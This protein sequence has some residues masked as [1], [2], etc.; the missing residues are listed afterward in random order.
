MTPPQLPPEM[1]GEI[2][3]YT[4]RHDLTVYC[5]ASKTFYE[6]SIAL[7]YAHI[8]V[9][10]QAQI[11][12][13]LAVLRQKP[14]L[15]ECV[16]SLKFHAFMGVSFFAVDV[17]NIFRLTELDI[18]CLGQAVLHWA[19]AHATLPCL[20]V[21]R[22]RTMGRL[23]SDTLASFLNRHPHI[24]TLTIEAGRPFSFNTVLILPAL[25]DVTG[26]P[27][28]ITS[29]SCRR[30]RRA[31]V[32][33]TQEVEDIVVILSRLASLSDMKLLALNLTV[34]APWPPDVI[35]AVAGVLPHIKSLTLQS[36]GSETLIRVD[37]INRLKIGDAV[38]KLTSLTHLEFGEYALVARFYD[39]YNPAR[40]RPGWR[41]GRSLVEHWSSKC[42]MLTCIG[43][44]GEIWEREGTWTITSTINRTVAVNSTFIPL[45]ST[46]NLELI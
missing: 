15:A 30:L 6:L 37:P 19:M 46:G 20:K 39:G 36:G 16:R 34:H 40:W 43:L 3:S 1:H 10:T 41:L 27:Q 13:L 45:T 31:A 18:S 35:L 11:D 26:P 33:W 23:N 22:A 8:V 28:L 21:F 44:Y 4:G 5:R 2:L 24:T 12:H 25:E 7:V 29:L 17:N 9:E 14:R 32:I 42:P 38:E